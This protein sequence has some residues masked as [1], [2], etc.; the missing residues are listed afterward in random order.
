MSKAILGFR[1]RCDIP[2]CSYFLHAWEFSSIFYYT[3]SYMEGIFSGLH[4]Y[5]LQLGLHDLLK[6]TVWGKNQE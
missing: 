6:L 3:N 1:G 2:S 5:I 4:V